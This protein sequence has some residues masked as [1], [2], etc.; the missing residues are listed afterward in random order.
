MLM[1]LMGT[2]DERRRLATL[3]LL[4]ALVHIAMIFFGN[5]NATPVKLLFS[6]TASTALLL[7]SH[8]ARRRLL[9]TPPSPPSPT[10]AP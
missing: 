8:Y 7:T 6:Y 3:L 10:S 5:E 2:G 1:R 4:I 9:S